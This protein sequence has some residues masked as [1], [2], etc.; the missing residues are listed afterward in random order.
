MA[1]TKTRGSTGNIRDSKPK[2]LGV[3]LQDGQRAKAG[4]ILVRQ[5]GTKITAG[6]N[7]GIGKDHTLFAKREG[8]VK[9]ARKRKINFNGLSKKVKVVSVL[10]GGAS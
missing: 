1:H 7:V 9:F 10:S 4:A 3:K 5:R 6:K 8:I 2:Y